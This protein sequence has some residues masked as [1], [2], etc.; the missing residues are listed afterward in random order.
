[1]RKGK[2]K[3]MALLMGAM[4]LLQPAVS[5]KAETQQPQEEVAQTIVYE[6]EVYELYKVEKIPSA[7]VFCSEDEGIR[8]EREV[9]NYY[10]R[11][12]SARAIAKGEVTQNTYAADGTRLATLKQ[13]TEWKYTL[14]QHFP[15]LISADTVITYQHSEARITILDS[16]TYRDTSWEVMYIVPYIVYYRNE[17]FDDEQIYTECNDYGKVW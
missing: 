7:T 1:M 10:Y 8:T 15:E 2:M 12:A 4:F 16:I 3:A 9:T 14:P 17:I 13:T 5:A 6:E 11:S